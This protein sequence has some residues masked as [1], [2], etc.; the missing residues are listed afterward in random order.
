[1]L[2]MSPPPITAHQRVAATYCGWWQGRFSNYQVL[3]GAALTATYTTYTSW[4]GERSLQV[5]LSDHF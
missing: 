1:M 2:M 4:L 5:S 3:G